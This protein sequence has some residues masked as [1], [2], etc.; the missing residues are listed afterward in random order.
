MIICTADVRGPQ[1]QS[2]ISASRVGVTNPASSGGKWSHA[3]LQ[4]QHR[5]RVCPMLVRSMTMFA[6]HLDALLF[7]HL[8]AS[9]AYT[10]GLVAFRR[11]PIRVAVG[12]GKAIDVLVRVNRPDD[13]AIVDDGKGSCTRMPWM[14]ES[15]LEPLHKRRQRMH[16]RMHADDI[17]QSLSPLLRA[18]TPGTPGLH[19]QSPQSRAACRWR[20]NVRTQF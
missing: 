4:H 8:S 6:F 3:R 18:L 20:S 2:R 13:G 7:K 19:P 5:L 1:R 14:A 11:S 15:P 12:V 10:A 16:F 9:D 17:S